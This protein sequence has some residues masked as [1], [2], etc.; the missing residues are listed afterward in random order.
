MSE[1]Q[2]IETA[3]LDENHW[4][5]DGEKVFLAFFRPEDFGW[6]AIL[7]DYSMIRIA[8]VIW[9]PLG[10]PEAPDKQTIEGIINDLEN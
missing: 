3:P 6:F 10:K 9:H 4:V 5:C 2:S 1:W 7:G 8:P